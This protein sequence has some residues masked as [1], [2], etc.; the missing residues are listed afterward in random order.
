ME[1]PLSANITGRGT[2]NIAE[3][4]SMR[5]DNSVWEVCSVVQV[6]PSDLSLW[7]LPNYVPVV[8]ME[9]ISL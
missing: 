8:N 4:T 1:S 7:D 6:S 2:E 3:E 9:R 5:R